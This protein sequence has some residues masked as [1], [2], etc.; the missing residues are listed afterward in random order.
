MSF[1]IITDSTANLSNEYL[2]KNSI[3]VV[4]LY[5]L[6]DGEVFPAYKTDKPELLEE[7]YQR[8]KNKPKLSTSCAN[9][10]QYYVEFEKAVK[11]AVPVLYIGFS[12]G[13]SATFSSAMIA[14]DRIVQNYPNAEIY[15]VDTLTGSFGQGYFVEQSVIMRENG[16]T[17]KEVYDYITSERERMNTYVTVDDLYYLHK[18]GRIPAI[19]YR[20]GTLVKI[21]PIIKVN[22]E[23]KLVS[24]AKVIFFLAQHAKPI[25]KKTPVVLFF[26]AY[27]SKGDSTWSTFI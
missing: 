3:S 17:A 18:G 10:D 8:I 9:D 16:K 20:I 21:K 4:T 13:V 24:T 11:S 6:L 14:K 25:N 26:V 23:G 15:C 1:K 12:S 27:R 19:A 7:F 2:Q 5:Y 22:G